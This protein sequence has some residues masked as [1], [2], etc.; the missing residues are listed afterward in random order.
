MF[1]F[2]DNDHHH[3]MKFHL[4][5]WKIKQVVQMTV[6]NLSGNPKVLHPEL[7][8]VGFPRFFIT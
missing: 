1:K 4:N 7:I 2:V 3:K 6:Y 5:G 8:V